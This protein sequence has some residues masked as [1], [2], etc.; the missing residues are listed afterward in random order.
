VLLVP[1]L[2][3]EPSVLGGGAD[4]LVDG[5]ATAPDVD[6][7]PLPLE[8]QETTVSVATMATPAAHTDL[9]E[10]IADPPWTSGPIVLPRAGTD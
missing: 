1:A 7:V 5:P 8:E 3:V 2:D 10:D 4:E 9:I 6:S